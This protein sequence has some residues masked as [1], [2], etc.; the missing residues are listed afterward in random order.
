MSARDPPSSG[1]GPDW[2]VVMFLNLLLPTRSSLAYRDNLSDEQLGE[3]KCPV[4]ILHGTEDKVSRPC[5]Q[6]G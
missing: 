2:R 1:C 6:I 4:L 3:I 5:S